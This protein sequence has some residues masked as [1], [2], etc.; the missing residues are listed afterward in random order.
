[1]WSKI[2]KPWSNISY[3]TQLGLLLLP[4]IIGTLVLIVVPAF[5]TIAISFTKYNALE[6]PTW[7]GLGNFRNLLASELVRLSLR[8][9]LIF[10]LTAVPL[11]LLGALV[12]AL[13]LQRKAKLFGLY[14]AAI[15]LPTVIPET[16]YALLWL[17]IFNPLYGPLNTVLGSVGLPTPAWLT[18]PNSAIAAIVIMSLFQIGEGFV[19]ILAGLQSIPRSLYEAAKVD[20]ASSW[21]SFWRISLPLIAPY[22]LLLSFRDLIISLQNTFAPT[23]IMTYGGPHYATTFVPL[24]IYEIAFDIFDFGLAAALL[25]LMYFL[26]GL[27]IVAIVNLTGTQGKAD[28]V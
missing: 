21:Y 16:A 27:L 8:N 23:F 25:L 1:M 15:Y 12:L 28:A 9:S 19:V 26:I 10:L 4:Y 13:L 24:L 14:R 18:E 20:G 3:Q 2:S 11:R 22:L 6:Q 5:A 7:V 17:W